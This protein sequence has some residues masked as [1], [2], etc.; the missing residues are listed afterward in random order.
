MSSSSSGKSTTFLTTET[1]RSPSAYHVDSQ[2]RTQRARQDHASGPTVTSNQVRHQAFT[3]DKTQ[4][5]KVAAIVHDDSQRFGVSPAFALRMAI[6]DGLASPKLKHGAGHVE[7][8]TNALGRGNPHVS[9][10][11]VTFPQSGSPLA[12]FDQVA[13]TTQRRKTNGA[14]SEPA[15][16]GT[17]TPHLTPEAQAFNKQSMQ[18][19]SMFAQTILRKRY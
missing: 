6:M 4:A 17:T 3:D 10:G 16:T 14:T 13:T 19:Q 11:T 15:L 7:A 8:S 18:Q 9:G 1:N 12:N 5:R 2:G